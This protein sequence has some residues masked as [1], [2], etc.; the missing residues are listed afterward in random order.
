MLKVYNYIKDHRSKSVSL[1]KV[2]TTVLIGI[3]SLSVHFFA[4]APQSFILLLITFASAFTTIVWHLLFAKQNFNKLVASLF[5]GLDNILVIAVMLPMAYTSALY[6]VLFLTNIIGVRFLLGRRLGRISIAF[7]LGL[8]VVVMGAYSFAG[9]VQNA[10]YYFALNFFP[11]LIINSLSSFSLNVIATLQRKQKNLE[12][13]N[14]KLDK[15]FNDLKRELFL[16]SQIVTSLNK[17]V[18]RRNIEIKNILNLSGQL[19]I[20][21]DSKKAIESFLYTV[22]GQLGCKHALILTQNNRENNYYSTFSAKGLKSS[23]LDRIRIYLGSNLL[24][25]FASTREPLLEKNIPKDDL[26]AD[27]V[28]MLKFFANDLF[29]PIVIKGELKGVLIVGEKLSGAKFSEEDINMISIVANQAA[30]V[31]EQ[32]MVTSEFQDIYFKTI[33]AMMKSL[34]AKYVFARGH[35]TRTANY[36]NIIA[37]KMGLSQTEIK[38]LTYGT[39]LHDVGKIAIRDEYLLDPNV[40]SENQPT[41]K[42]K[43]LEHTIKGAS[44]LK[45]SGFEENIVNL[46][47]HHHEDFNGKGFPHGLGEL[48]IPF[49]VRILSVC[50]TYDAMTS[51]RPHRKALP[52]VTAREYL[53]YNSSKK[54]DPQVVKA[55][56]NEL[57]IN[58]EMQKFH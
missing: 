54:F 14:S 31:M 8:F 10:I 53:E 33:K 56:L 25:T 52:D 37:Q 7:A 38:E 24:N 43:I 48:D 29:C 44:I 23:D 9:L 6:P 21:S 3:V 2:F 18:K 27:E 20:N 17:D 32:T 51:D 47:M 28:K 16:N 13:E 15:T 30:F 11:A 57:S 42:N 49:G 36:V 22:I 50:N 19:N 1:F 5:L 46:A 39:L 41:M 55:F 34:E 12:F 40:F 35:N 45:S 26:Y 58:K 4:A